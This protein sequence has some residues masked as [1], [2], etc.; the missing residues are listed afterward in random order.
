MKKAFFEAQLDVM[1][2]DSVDIITTS[3]Y[4]SG[5]SSASTAETV[6][7]PKDGFHGED[8]PF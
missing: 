3:G 2:F 1:Y 6:F 8:L 4:G 7:V 5:N